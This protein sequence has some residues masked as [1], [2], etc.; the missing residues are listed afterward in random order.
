MSYKIGLY[1]RVSTEEQALRTEGSLDSQMH[2]LTGYVDIK[3]MQQTNWGSTIEKY[4]DDG[5]SAKDTNRPALQRLLKDL[6]KGK[7]NMILVT[8]LSR[9]SRSIRDFCGLLDLF[10]ETKGQFLSLK[11]QFDTTTAAGEMM[12]FN[13]INLAQFERRQISERVSMN[14]HSRS[15][16]GLRNGG[17]VP[18]GF[19][20]DHK[21]KATLLID[22]EEATYVKTIFDTY[23]SEGSL[24]KAAAKLREMGIPSKSKSSRWSTTSTTEWSSP[25]VL[26]TLRNFFYVGMR[27][28]NKRNK[29][30][31]KN[32]LKSHEHYQLVK[33][34]WPAI[35]DETTFYV[36]QRT[37]DENSKNERTRLSSGKRRF[38][39]LSGLLTC[40][41]CGRSMV[42]AAG[43]G[44]G[45]QVFQY[46][47][48]RP[49]E[50][51]ASKCRIKT[52]RADDL[53]ETIVNHLARIVSEEGYFDNLE[54][55]ISEIQ[56]TGHTTLTAQKRDA[57]KALSQTAFDIRGV[58]RLQSGTEDRVSLKLYAERLNE[59]DLLR[60][61]QEGQLA[62]ISSKL[63]E[64][65]NP[66]E[67]RKNIE[68]NI[69]R[70]HKAWPKTP[71][72]LRKKL[73]QTVFDKLLIEVDGIHIFYFAEETVKATQSTGAIPVDLSI[74]RKNNKAES[75]SHNEKVFGFDIV[76]V[77][78]GSRI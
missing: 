31:S 76:G 28:V 49:I 72:A 70:F 11:E 13:M 57:E 24:Y 15:M 44:R 14:F 40:A 5:F 29:E 64:C 4:I 73:I 63:E 39:L 65:P 68:T 17:T 30:K 6:R 37:L 77:G 52:I 16:R 36:V 1:I 3:N 48:H 46:Y 62:I 38:Y 34:S 58:I 19:K 75:P 8:D 12:L 22:D 47:V 59:L 53:E 60:N 2:R 10:K 7:I 69:K 51:K 71:P 66:M 18:L 25:M 32:E 55:K 56:A 67:L 23:I 35:I 33:A 42:G 9:L 78:C 41:E 50:G 26:G 45:D 61:D 74:Y 20:L 54:D 43:H 27:E 21:N